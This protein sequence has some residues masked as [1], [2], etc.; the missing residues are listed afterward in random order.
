[1]IAAGDL[2]NLFNGG[3]NFEIY[4]I[5]AVNYQSPLAPG[6]VCQ[7]GFVQ[8]LVSRMNDGSVKRTFTAMPTRALPLEFEAAWYGVW[9]K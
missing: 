6:A 2:R 4:L 1:L 5:G 8:R 3:R 9:A 7:T